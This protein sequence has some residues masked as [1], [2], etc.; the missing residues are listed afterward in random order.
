[1]LISKML[2]YL[3]DTAQKKLF[4]KNKKMGPGKIIKLFFNLNFFRAF[5]T[6]TSLHFLN[7]HKILDFLIPYITY[8]KKKKNFTSRSL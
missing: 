2:T 3:G 8:F 4:E 1:M 5:V 6:N 7:Q